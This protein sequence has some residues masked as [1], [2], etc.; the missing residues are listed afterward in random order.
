[1][2]EYFSVRPNKGSGWR[3]EVL[4]NARFV[5]AW[6]FEVAVECMNSGKVS[7]NGHPHVNR[8]NGI[9]ILQ[10]MQILHY[11]IFCHITITCRALV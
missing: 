3:A 1:M 10:M 9:L 2:Y 8:M 11:P 7:T 6:I 4:L 5:S